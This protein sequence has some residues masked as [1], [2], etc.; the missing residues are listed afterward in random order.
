M[1]AAFKSLFPL[2]I[3]LFANVGLKAQAPTPTSNPKTALELNE[4]YV[5]IIGTMYEKGT[6]W[7]NAFKEK[8]ETKH[9][10]DLKPFSKDM[11]NYITGKEKELKKMKDIGGSKEF[12][13]A[14]IEFLGFEKR[15]VEKALVPF[16]KLPANASQA[17][18]EA[19][20]NNL[21]ETSREEETKLKVVREI[22][23]KYAEKNNFKIEEKPAE[24]DVQ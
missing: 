7:G 16:E 11:L 23:A 13:D 20:E 22:Q 24:Q 3:L 2:L 4:Y 12:N 15:L 18:I 8:S 14:M 21:V 1:R 17:E 9:F 19:A 10:A 6:A 5:G